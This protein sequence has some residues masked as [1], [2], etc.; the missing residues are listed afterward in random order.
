MVGGLHDPTGDRGTPGELT[1]LLPM[2]TALV[3]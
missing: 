1:E 2:G 3:P